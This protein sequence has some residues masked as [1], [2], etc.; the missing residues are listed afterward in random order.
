MQEP[1]KEQKSVS[2]EKPEEERKGVFSLTLDQLYEKGVVCLRPD[3]TI[4]DAAKK[5]LDYHVGDI[6]VTEEK[7]GKNFPIGIVTD[8][9]IVISLITHKTV[10]EASKLSEIMSGTV[11]TASKDDDLTTLV[12]RLVDKGISRLPIVDSSGALVGILSSKKI[13]QYFVQGLSELSTISVLQQEREQR[14]H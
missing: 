3:N 1:T 14:T 7:E 5:M 13:F 10:T 2:Q 11:I 6:V 9:D 8:R 12:R 4:L